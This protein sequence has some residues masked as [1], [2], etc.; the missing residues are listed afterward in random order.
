MK[1]DMKG[2]CALVMGGSK[3]I[4]RGIAHGLAQ[5]GAHVCLIARNPDS[6]DEAARQIR[7]DTGATVHTV[8]ADLSRLE[9]IE[10]TFKEAQ[11]AMGQVDILINNAGGPKFGTLLTL[12]EQ[13]WQ[14]TVNLTLLST[15]RMTTLAV[16]GMQ[17]RGWGRIVTVTSA[18][19]KE[20]VA[21]MILSC[22]ARAGVT[23]F[24]KALATELAPQGIT[25]NVVAPGGVLTDRIRSLV[26]TKADLDNVPFEDALKQNEKTIPLGRFATPDEFAAYVVF[27]C[28]D[29]ARYITGTALNIDGGLSKSAF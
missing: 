14:D 15:V 12:T 19:A 18:T 16:P 28:S 8:A 10:R 13:D 6:L 9:D 21:P 7:N 23:A 5:E 25:A 26:K 1:T 17:A 2:R 22:T 3:G 24:M 27:L 29:Q 20:P 4:G 11:S